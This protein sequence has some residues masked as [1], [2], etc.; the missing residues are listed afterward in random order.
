MA[1]PFALERRLGLWVSLACLV[2]A[3]Q[4]APPQPTAAPQALANLPVPYKAKSPEY[5]AQVFI[6]GHPNSTKRDLDLI[7][8]LEFTWQKSLFQWRLIEGECKGCF[9]WSESDRVVKASTDAGMKIIARLDFQPKWARADEAH[10]GPPDTYQD[11][12]NFVSAL[13]SRYRSGSSYG[14]LH[15]IEVWNEVNLAREWGNKPI[16]REQ[17]GDYVRLLKLAYQAAKAADPE[18]TVMT[19]GLSPTGWD[20]D[21]AR[22]D[23]VYLQWLYEAGM[24]GYYDVLGAHANTQAPEPELEI[25]SWR[26]CAGKP[27]EHGSFYFRR[28]EQLRDIMVKNG[29]AEKQ[30]WLLEFGWTSDKIYQDYAWYAIPEDQKGENLVRAFQY[31]VRNWSPWIGVMTVWT[32]PD[33]TWTEKRE[34]YWW[35]I[36]EPNGAPREAYRELLRNRQKGQLP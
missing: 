32:L 35:A 24:K 30:V 22:P 14:R 21:T 31:A 19:A 26:G 8:Q 23:D 17:A 34:E 7:R 4:T 27:C 16:N 20:D 15:A 25:G 11:F 12:A 29:D 1:N 2:A 33:P 6:W 10:N 13:V 3:C 5:G 28:V 18:V 36:T 9:D